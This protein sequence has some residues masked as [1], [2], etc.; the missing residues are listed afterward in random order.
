MS[1]VIDLQTGG[2]G[3]PVAILSWVCSVKSTL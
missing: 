2:G 3:A 1:N